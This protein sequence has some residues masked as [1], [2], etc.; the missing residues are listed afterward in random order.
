M[1]YLFD[2]LL[3]ITLNGFSYY[4]ASFFLDNELA[5]WQALLIGFSVVTLGAL[6]EAAGSPMWLIVLVPFPVGMFLLYTFLDETL[7]HWFLTYGITLAIYT[8]IHI[9]M[10]YFFKFHSLIP[11]WKLKKA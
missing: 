7:A 4:I 11:A 10:S 5:F 3:A 9:P 8:V 6:T 1:K 2:Y